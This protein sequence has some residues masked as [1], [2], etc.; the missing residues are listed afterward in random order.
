MVQ[1]LRTAFTLK[2]FVDDCRINK[3]IKEVYNQKG[4]DYQFRTFETA[5]L[6]HEQEKKNLLVVRENI[7]Y[8]NRQADIFTQ[9]GSWFM[10]G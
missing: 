4:S 1:Y 6:I 8:L 3:T 7:D 5:K 10:V 9:G 2:L